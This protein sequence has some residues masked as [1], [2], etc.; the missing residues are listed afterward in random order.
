MKWF[1]LFIG[2]TLLSSDNVEKVRNQFPY[3]NSLEACETNIQLLQNEDTAA[4][5]AYTAAMILMK[6]RFVKSPIKK[7]QNFRKGKVAL[8]QIIIENPENLE[9]RYIRYGFQKNIPIFLGYNSNIEEDLNFLEKNM[10]ASD[11]SNSYKKKMIVNLLA[12]PNNTAQ[13]NELLTSVFQAL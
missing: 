10:P 8:D 6:S 1:I 3:I 5:K 9:F 7:Y 2:I 4:A 13:Q 12:I 11:Y